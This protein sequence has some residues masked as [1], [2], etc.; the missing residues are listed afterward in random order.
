M[1]QRTRFD[2]RHSSTSSPAAAS[3]AGL[4][5][6]WCPPVFWDW[7]RHSSPP[8]ERCLTARESESVLR[9]SPAD[10]SPL[11]R[12]RRSNNGLYDN[13]WT[14]KI[15][16]WDTIQWSNFGV[17]WRQFLNYIL[18][19]CSKGHLTPETTT[20]HMLTKRKGF[21]LMSWMSGPSL[22]VVPSEPH[23]CNSSGIKRW[24][25]QFR[26]ICCIIVADVRILLEH[27][28]CYLHVFSQAAACLSTIRAV[29]SCYV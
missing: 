21:T 25:S 27:V 10:E 20:D 28:C 9:F 24:L 19:N 5:V 7:C 4:W 13:W 14:A 11:R 3:P 8:L 29:A 23:H 12:R 17:V 6:H 15:S 16:K 18:Y 2:P 1:V 26:V 22:T